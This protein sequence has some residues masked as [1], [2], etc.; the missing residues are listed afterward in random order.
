[1]GGR[2]SSGRVGLSRGQVLAAAL[3]TADAEGLGALSVRGLAARLGV[4]PMALYRHVDGKGALL[5]GIADLVLGELEL[6]AEGP[7][8]WRDRLRET[9]RSLRA[10]LVRHP[11][12]AALL[13][14]RPLFTPA[15]ARVADRMLGLFRG[16]GFSPERSALLYQQVARYLL[17]LLLLETGGGPRLAAGERRER[18]RSARAALRAF[19]AD[20]YPHLAEAAP[21]LAAPYDPERAF[22][23]ALDLLVAGLERE[24]AQ[25]VAR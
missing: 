3:A 25:A 14:D 5:D 19:G 17:A 15:G 20:E 8:D 18:A 9:A 7:G 6:P 12:A 10:A 11:A 2:T 22:E 13:A 16:A 21:H 4:T 1:M 24:L 23:S